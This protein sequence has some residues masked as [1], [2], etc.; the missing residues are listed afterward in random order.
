MVQARSFLVF[1]VMALLLFSVACGPPPEPPK[2]I[3]K[4]FKEGDVVYKTEESFTGSEKSLFLMG[5]GVR[6]R[7]A[8]IPVYAMGFY[9]DTTEAAK[10]L[11][12]WKGMELEKIQADENYYLA[13]Q[14][15]QFD[16]A[17]RLVFVRDVEA[18]AVAEAFDESI[19][20]RLKTEG[21][22]EALKQFRAFFAE[23]VKNG[24]EIHFVWSA[25]GKKLTTIIN[26]NLK[27]TIENEDLAQALLAVYL[28]K[29]PI[30]EDAKKNFAKNLQF[31]HQRAEE[32]AK[33]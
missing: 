7:F 20:S 30:S 29:E 24:E 13:L 21:G 14:N 11:A 1:C 3:P 23:E 12:T 5:T 9:I 18:E 16:K 8:I 28:D 33:P 2:E 22:K 32:L 10:A 26:G 19:N 31:L 17:M 25:D 27:G 6:I 4:E 15:G